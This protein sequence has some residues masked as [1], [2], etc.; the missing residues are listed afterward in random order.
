MDMCHFSLKVKFND[1]VNVGPPNYL[2][3][4]TLLIAK[5]PMPYH[6]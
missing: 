3:I 2:P 4:F 6:R 5:M 1:S